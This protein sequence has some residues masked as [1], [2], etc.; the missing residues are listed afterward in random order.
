MFF[1]GTNAFPSECHDYYYRWVREA[2][3]STPFSTSSPT[4]RYTHTLS[5]TH[6]QLTTP[7]RPWPWPSPPRASGNIGKYLDTSVLAGKELETMRALAHQCRAAK[8]PYAAFG[9]GTGRWVLDDDNRVV[10][11]HMNWRFSSIR[12]V[13]L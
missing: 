8:R 5:H 7:P 12:P 4:L 2:D 1:S 10:E 9:R 6:T 13:D 11:V 3:R